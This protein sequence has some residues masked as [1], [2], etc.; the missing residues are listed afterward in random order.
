MKGKRHFL[1]MII[2]YIKNRLQEATVAKLEKRL[3]IT[4]EAG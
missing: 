4:H 1:K 3:E 2:G